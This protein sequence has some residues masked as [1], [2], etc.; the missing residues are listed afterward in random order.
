M[1][2]RKRRMTPHNQD[3]RGLLHRC[4][5]NL[6]GLEPLD[7]GAG[8]VSKSLLADFLSWSNYSDLHHGLTCVTQ[9][10]RHG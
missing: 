10:S 5:A 3:R 2:A 6:M 1:T 4:R 8:G 7:M 9:E